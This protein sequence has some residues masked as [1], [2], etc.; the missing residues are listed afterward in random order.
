[1]TERPNRE[2]DYDHH[3]AGYAA[4]WE[5]MARELHASPY[6]LAWSPHYGGFWVLGSWEDAKRVAEDWETFSSDNDPKNE[7]SGGKGL[8]IPQNLYPL[9]LSESD[10]PHSTERRMIE[11]P[12][13]LPKG[14]KR[15]REIAR[16]YLADSLS[17]V[18]AAG[19]AD[20]MSDIIIP[21]AARTTLHLVGFD[22]DNWQD[23][24][25][26]AHRVSF[27]KLGDPD[28]PAV[29]LDRIRAS[30]R[31]MLA[32]RR[33]NPRDDLVTALTRGMVGG[34]PLPD[35]AAESMMS[36]L[37]FAGFDTIS[38]AAAS[39]L[40]WLADHPEEHPR[41]LA[42]DDYLT[43][44][45]HEFLRVFTPAHQVARTVM[46]EVELGSQR[47]QSGE[48]VL[49]WF[50]AA[51]RDPH[52][53]PD[54]DAVK[55]DR[56]NAR[57]HLTFS[58]G[59]HRCLGALLAQE[60]LRMIIRSMLEQLPNFKVDREALVCYPSFGTVAGYISIPITFTPRSGARP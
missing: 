3:S 53:Y 58:A 16:G 4:A 7:R 12:F 48:R 11:A 59:Q 17:K 34:Q 28:Y 55:L 57:D 45:V 56:P 60:E 47:L 18:L 44:A 32:D 51:N 31:E 1:M 6:P 19:R 23:A 46:R 14:L 20:L 54:P 25:L 15:A 36:A 49:L 8:A 22:M 42:D 13:F 10:P 5:A 35:E 29:E 39:A 38:T 40:I 26:S 21:T 30:F 24:A 52:K 41:L 33:A 9:I 50:A 2:I 43:S 27:T 37:V